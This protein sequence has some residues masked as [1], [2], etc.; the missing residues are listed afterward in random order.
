M[1]I[2]IN[3][4]VN[5]D[6][7]IIKMQVCPAGTAYYRVEYLIDGI[8]I[9]AVNTGAMY[10]TPNPIELLDGQHCWTEYHYQDIPNPDPKPSDRPV[11]SGTAGNRPAWWEDKAKT[12]RQ[13]IL[14]NL[15]QVVAEGDNGN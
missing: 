15:S 11:G 13:A 14:D 9:H 12:H 8:C 3:D 4:T 5:T 10:G 6:V 2:R 1:K 7:R